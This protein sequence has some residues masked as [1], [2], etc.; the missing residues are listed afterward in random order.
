MRLFNTVHVWGQTA[1]IP[2]P[3]E[4]LLTAINDAKR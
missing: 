2:V 3:G 1:D 4:K